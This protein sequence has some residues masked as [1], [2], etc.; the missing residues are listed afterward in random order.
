MKVVLLQLC[1]EPGSQ[2]LIEEEKSFKQAIS[3]SQ[4][5]HLSQMY[6]FQVSVVQFYND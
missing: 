6:H 5:F 4:K 3:D 1:F 2:F